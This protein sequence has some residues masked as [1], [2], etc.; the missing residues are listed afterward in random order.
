MYCIK[1]KDNSDK[2]CKECGCRI[3][4]GKEDEDKQLMCDECNHPYHM[5]CLT[6]PLKE[7]PR[8][9]W[10][11]DFLIN[12]YLFFIMLSVLMCR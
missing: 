12:L 2:S 8:D 9:D 7:M 1:C 3:C 10:L 5:E 11:V 6:P 4:G